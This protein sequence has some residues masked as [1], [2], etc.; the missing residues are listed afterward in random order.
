MLFLLL[1]STVG[2][3]SFACGVRGG[4]LAGSLP[5]PVVLVV[6][7]DVADA[8]VQPDAVVLGAHS[9]QLG[10]ELARIA[11]RLQVRPLGLDVPE[12]G[13]SL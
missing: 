11:N 3:P 2:D 4:G 13:L 12:Q 9:G 10:F 8:G 7:G 6:G 5:A 1:G